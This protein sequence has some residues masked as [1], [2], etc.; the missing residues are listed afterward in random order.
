M[1]CLTTFKVPIR[2]FF[3]DSSAAKGASLLGIRQELGALW[4]H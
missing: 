1:R 4:G 3:L 2:P